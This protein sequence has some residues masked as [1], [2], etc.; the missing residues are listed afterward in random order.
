MLIAQPTA[1]HQ[2]WEC[3]GCGHRQWVRTGPDAML[4]DQAILDCSACPLMA[5]INIEVVK[6]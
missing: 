4:C 5:E 6:R 2:R 3:P 1:G